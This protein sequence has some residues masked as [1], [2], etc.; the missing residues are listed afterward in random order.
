VKR[1]FTILFSALTATLFAAEEDFY[2]LVT[3]PVPENIKLEVSG[4]ASLPDGRISV[5]VR[6]GEIWIINNVYDASPTNVTY[7]LF[8]SG[9]HEPLGLAFHKGSLYTA[10]RTEVT[11]LRDMDGDGRADEYL[12]VAKGWGVTGNYHEYAYGPVFD[13]GN[14]LWLTLNCTIGSGVRT[15]DAWRGW[16]LKIKPDGNWEPVSGGFRSPRAAIR[17]KS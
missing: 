10:Q 3:I 15:N 16:S 1:L 7:K 8:A 6:K 14:N 5:A 4:I 11:R 12:T 2:R 13:F 17:H 9:L